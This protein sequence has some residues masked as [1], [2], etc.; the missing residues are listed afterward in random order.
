MF[1]HLHTGQVQGGE[2]RGRREEGGG[3][4]SL[5]PWGWS[6]GGRWRERMKHFEAQTDMLRLRVQVRANETSQLCISVCF[7]FAWALMQ[8]S[9]DRDDGFQQ[10]EP[11][12]LYSVMVRGWEYWQ[13]GHGR[14]QLVCI[15]GGVS[16]HLFCRVSFFEI[17]ETVELIPDLAHFAS[18]VHSRLVSGFKT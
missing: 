16:R 8:Q 5:S 1:S 15:C 10:V 12:W 7:C 2:A 4:G 14:V 13:S 9:G 17:K 18:T 6:K 3:R 11:V